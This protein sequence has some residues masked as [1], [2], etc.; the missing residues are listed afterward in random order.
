MRFLTG[1]F[2]RKQPNKDNNLSGS[3]VSP[4]HDQPYKTKDNGDKLLHTELYPDDS[5][6]QQPAYV[7]RIG[8]VLVLLTL[9]ASSW[10]C[11]LGPG[12]SIL[13]TNLQKLAIQASVP[14]VFTFTPLKTST[15]PL[16]P[17]NTA[18]SPSSTLPAP[19]KT[20]TLVPS[21]TFVDT[22]TVTMEPSPT[23]VPI[24][25]TPTPTS[26]VSGCVPAELITLA[27]VGKDLC[28]SGRVFRTIDKPS[29]FII[30]VVEEPDAFYYVAYDL[31]YEGLEKKQC[32]Y[33]SGEI[34][35]L[36]INPIMVLSYSTPLQFCP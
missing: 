31:R 25:N 20:S 3:R 5:P 23:L 18:G 4:T 24:Q 16:K 32:I 2:V 13:E 8:L 33:A 36:G 9:A 21:S 22:A 27:D 15:P 17:T 34:R 14:P 30:V 6:L 19:S 26:E 11:F 7:R 29:S 35:Q 10:F 28:V 12:A 1:K